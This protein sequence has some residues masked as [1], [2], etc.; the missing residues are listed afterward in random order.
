MFNK[1]VIF[2]MELDIG[3]ILYLSN[4]ELE[5]ILP[6]VIRVYKSYEDGK[7]FKCGE[8]KDDFSNNVREPDK[9]CDFG[10]DYEITIDQETMFKYYT[11]ITPTSTIE[12]VKS[13]EDNY[14][15]YLHNRKNICF[16]NAK[17]I[18]DYLQ[19]FDWDWDGLKT[20]FL[21]NS[22]EDLINIFER[23]PVV[24]KFVDSVITKKYHPV[25]KMNM[26]KNDNISNFELLT[27]DK[28]I[29]KDSD[30][31]IGK[32]ILF[33]SYNQNINMKFFDRILM[34]DGFEQDANRFMKSIYNIENMINGYERRLTVNDIDANSVY[35]IRYKRTTSI[36][37]LN[38]YVRRD[39]IVLVMNIDSLKLYVVGYNYDY[40]KNLINSIL[41]DGSA[42]SK[43]E[44]SKFLSD[45]TSK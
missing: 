12:I 11:A 20:Y 29:P 15:I 39:R 28:Y 23:T 40:S 42:M 10:S 7:Y 41:N 27:E 18:S 36:E 37:N 13:E 44:I 19:H 14:F 21:N 9:L 16:M 17:K 43:D 45:K 8:I 38:K 26:Y 34:N 32:V 33:L 30:I 25:I 4:K 35:I 6:K 3:T 2:M 31:H 1:G 24:N 5:G 22:T